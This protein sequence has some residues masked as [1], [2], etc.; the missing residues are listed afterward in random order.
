MNFGRFTFE[1]FYALGLAIIVALLLAT[2]AA[3]VAVVFLR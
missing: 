1:I 2:G 3:G